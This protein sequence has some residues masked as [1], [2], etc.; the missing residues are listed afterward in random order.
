MAK[1][2]PCPAPKAFHSHHTPILN[3]SYLNMNSTYL[4]ENAKYIPCPLPKA[5]HFHHTPILSSSYLNMNSTYVAGNA[6]Y[7]PCPVPKALL[8]TASR[9]CYFQLGPRKLYQ[10]L[11]KL[12]FMACTA[13]PKSFSIY[14]KQNGRLHAE[15][16]WRPLFEKGSYPK[17]SHTHQESLCGLHNG[18]AMCSPI[19]MVFLSK[20]YHK[21]GWLHPCG[22]GSISC[23]VY[24]PT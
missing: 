15:S 19:L 14:T 5:I 23:K 10:T 21:L 1:Y 13:V 17:H 22:F 16:S 4:L 2:I 20:H 7:I 18:V 24:N 11:C 6:Q 9:R 8:F 3:P 12:I